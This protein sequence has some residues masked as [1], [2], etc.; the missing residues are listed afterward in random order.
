MSRTA[1]LVICGAGITGVAAAH[2]LSKAGVKDI[3][4]LDERAPLSLTSD[5]STECYRNWWPDTAM[6][7]LM[8][9]SI[10]LMEEL[11]EENANVFNM[12]RRGY[13]YMT[14]DESKVPALI[15]RSKRTSSLG[16]GPLRTHLSDGRSNYQ[17]APTEGF[18]NQPA[19]ADL[20][21]GSDLIQS[22]YPYLQSK[23]VA[24]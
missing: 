11:A 14:G 2:Y 1:G 20:L 12:N 9:G 4:L 22:K 6:L 15:E 17:P 19:G 3:L 24:A 21:L 8:N 10:D 7:S 5:R 13:L 18:K 23:A 16:G